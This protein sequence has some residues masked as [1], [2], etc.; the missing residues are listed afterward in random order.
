M[1]YAT[2][3]A[4]AIALALGYG[5][6]S[7]HPS[8]RLFDH[9]PAPDSAAQDIPGQEASAPVGAAP[10]DVT[11]EGGG[12]DRPGTATLGPTVSA[13]QGVAEMRKS[14][15]EQLASVLY[16]EAGGSALT[17]ARGWQAHGVWVV[18]EDAAAAVAQARRFLS[19]GVRVQ[20][21]WAG[22]S[23]RLPEPVSICVEITQVFAHSTG[24]SDAPWLRVWDGRAL[25]GLT[26]ADLVAVML[27]GPEDEL[28]PIWP[29]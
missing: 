25:F 21:I 14:L 10:G 11:D 22:P 17:A 1:R 23:A 12:H 16:D 8:G 7:A 29:T 19:A 13:T 5:F 9:L 24:P 20:A 26:F 4:A 2:D 15:L 18:P 6:G 3:R 27:A 28:T